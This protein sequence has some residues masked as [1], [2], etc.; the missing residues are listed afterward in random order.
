MDADA[1]AAIVE[2]NAAA[3]HV[4]GVAWGVVQHGELVLTRGTGA[5]VAG[6]SAPP[7]AS[8]P[9]R[10][11]S[12]TKSFTA[13]AVL[14]L[15]DEGAVA[16]DDPIARY[17]PE[18]DGFC[19]PTTDAPTLTVRHLLT[20]A[21]GWATDDAWADRH[22]DATPAELSVV[23]AAGPTSADT[24]GVRFEYSNTGYAALGRLLANVTGMS[25]QQVITEH[26][27]GPLGLSSTTW[28][29]PDGAATGYRWQDG[30]WLEEPALDDGEY[31]PMGGLWSTVTDIARWVGWFLDAFPARDDPDPGPLR[32]ATRREMQQAHRAFP[33]TLERGSDGSPDR[34]MAGGYGFGLRVV[35]ELG[36]RDVVAHSGGL[37]GFGSN[38]RWLPEHGTGVV[39]LGNVTYAPMGALTARLVDAL[40]ERDE[41]GASHRAP[42]D[43]VR[44][45]AD[46]LVALLGE[47]DDGRAGQLFADNVALDEDH[48]RRRGAAEALGGRPHLV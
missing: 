48:G 31:G 19:G 32:R 34:L 6:A 3:H 9:F 25:A 5:K 23:L 46:G 47:W 37:P 1:L 43:L 38:M 10:I 28:T 33:T 30:G 2:A 13:A 42:D 39:A 18:L 44:A 24:A 14:V 45:A 22:L 21:A 36:P 8:T 4:P 27:L 7:D 12:M 41:L 29:R 16:L 11:A 40:A 15:R 35:H 17:V 26:L 20:M